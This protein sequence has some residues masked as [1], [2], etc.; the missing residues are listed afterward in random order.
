MPNVKCENLDKP[1][2][3][4]ITDDILGG[5]VMKVKTSVKAGAY[6][7]TSVAVGR[8]EKSAASG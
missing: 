6:V 8:G 5:F 1:V 7:S 4:Y 2:I 3:W